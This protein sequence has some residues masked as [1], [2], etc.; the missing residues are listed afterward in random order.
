MS[1]NKKEIA[2]IRRRFAPEK[3]AI[4]VVRGCYVNERK[5]I[6]S[7]F[8]KSPLSLP[9]S[10]AEHYM[11]AFKKTLGGA[12]GRN[13]FSISVPDSQLLRRLQMS[14]LKDEASV[15]EF[16]RSVIGALEFEGSYL[17]LMM[18]DAWDL[19]RKKDAEHGDRPDFDGEVFNYIMA[20]V[21]PVKPTK[22][23]LTFF[24]DDRQFHTAEPDLAVGGP[25]LGFMYPA[26][27]DGGANV[28]AAQFYTKDASDIH[29][30][31]IDAVFG[32]EAPRSAADQRQIFYDALSDTLDDSMSF[33]VVQTIHENL[34]AQLA[35]RKKD[36]EP[37]EVSR[38]EI[39]SLLSS[40]D[41]PQSKIAAFEEE[42]LEQFGAVGLPA[43]T[44]AEAKRFEI[45]TESATV[46]VAPDRSDLV[47]MKRIDGRRCIVIHV[48]GD[49]T[50]NGVEVNI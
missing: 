36:A 48:E 26:F 49:V 30:D 27:E 44:I 46:N 6:V 14:E 13:L 5:E 40:C 21:C 38:R 16:Y 29:A 43:G 39:S 31:F 1:M 11:S 19:P 35:E 17:I 47:E 50:V 24:A 45:A 8:A 9:E 42:Y 25:A 10:E 18:H 22:P 2:Q 33:D 12:Q 32:V 28:S 7:T 34:T 41:V 23:L 15:E 3:N 4:S 20:V 37:L